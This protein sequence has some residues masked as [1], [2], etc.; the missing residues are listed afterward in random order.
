MSRKK[1]VRLAALTT[2]ANVF[3]GGHRG[4]AWFERTFGPAQ[5]IIL[6]LGCGR[7]EYTLALARTR[8]NVGILGVDRNGSRLWKGA[9]KALDEGFSNAFFLHAP[10]EYLGDHVPPRRVGEIWLPFPDPL[11]KTRQASHRLVSPIFLDRYRRLLCRGG[12]IHLKS[13]DWELVTFADRAVR[14]V[15][16]QVLESRSSL[17]DADGTMAMVQTTYER[18]YRDEGRTIFGRTF[19]FE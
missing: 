17:T 13:D 12:T 6:E 5:P 8:P 16:G 19:S 18:R 7:G 2:M 11:P 4:P 10:I 1:Q 14:T 9:A 3:D 15:G